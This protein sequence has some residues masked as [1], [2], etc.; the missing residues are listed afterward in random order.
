MRVKH[1]QGSDV[2]GDFLCADRKELNFIVS[3]ELLIEHPCGLRWGLEISRETSRNRQARH[4]SD[5]FVFA[6]VYIGD[7]SDE[8][9]FKRGL[10]TRRDERN[11]FLGIQTFN[12]DSEENFVVGLSGKTR[13]ESIK[14]SRVL[15]VRVGLGVEFFHLQHTDCLSFELTV[16]VY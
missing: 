15:R 2:R 6:T 7:G 16:L 9:I 12:S 4:D 8:I 5:F 13:L 3:A 10:R 14:D 11:R 1:D